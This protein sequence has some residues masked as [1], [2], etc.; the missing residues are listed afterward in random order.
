MEVRSLSHEG[1]SLSE[2][3]P[4]QSYIANN[5]S[6]DVSNVITVSNMPES[7]SC[8]SVDGFTNK[9]GSNKTL[10]LIVFKN[11]GSSLIESD[12]LTPTR[13]RRNSISGTKVNKPLSRLNRYSEHVKKYRGKL[14]LSNDLPSIEEEGSSKHNPTIKER[15][16]VSDSRLKPNNKK[17]ISSIN[18]KKRYKSGSDLEPICYDIK[19]RRNQSE[20]LSPV[21][22]AKKDFINIPKRKRSKSVMNFTRTIAN[23]GH[24]KRSNL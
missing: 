5:N 8:S 6:E 17:L 4:Y 19:R 10:N 1:P 13:L 14:T 21:V 23:F 12:S 9:H 3:S 2:G 20:D 7:S 11:A 18:M 22:G 16:F 15:N 24:G